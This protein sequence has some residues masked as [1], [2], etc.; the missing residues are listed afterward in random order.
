MT[1]EDEFVCPHC[2]S[3]ATL[4]ERTEND[5]KAIIPKDL[6]Y[7]WQKGVKETTNVYL[8]PSPQELYSDKPTTDLSSQ[9]NITQKRVSQNIPLES[10]LPTVEDPSVKLDPASQRVYYQL[11]IEFQIVLDKASNYRD[12]VHR[13]N[14][15]LPDRLQNYGLTKEA[16]ERISRTGDSDPKIQEQLNKILKRIFD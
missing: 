12:G 11:S 1:K 16:W 14:L 8:P 2:G 3:Q 15:I 10:I 4:T 9:A 7:N 6:Q 5:F 13:W